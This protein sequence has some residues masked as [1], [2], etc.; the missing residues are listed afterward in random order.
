MHA[1]EAYETVHSL[2]RNLL[3]GAAFRALNG[4]LE[5]FVEAMDHRMRDPDSFT[6]PSE[7]PLLCVLIGFAWA[8]A[9]RWTDKVHEKHGLDGE[10]E[11]DAADW[12]KPLF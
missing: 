9:L 2:P 10:E 8:Y 6:W 1:I 7:D 3:L 12:W 4:E 11:N 5:R